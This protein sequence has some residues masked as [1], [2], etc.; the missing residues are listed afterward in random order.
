MKYSAIVAVC[1]RGVGVTHTDGNLDYAARKRVLDTQYDGELLL[2]AAG[3]RLNGMRPRAPLG[4]C[5]FLPAK[6]R[7]SK[8]A[9]SNG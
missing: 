1:L 3:L 4:A 7:H 8:A 5:R 2:T 9:T 6:E